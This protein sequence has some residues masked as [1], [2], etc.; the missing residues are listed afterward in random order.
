MKTFLTIF[1]SLAIL[2]IGTAQ[3]TRRVNNNVGISGT[4]VY[5]TA[6]AAHDAA[7]ANDIIIVDPSSTTYG[8]LTLTK[9]LK[10]YG[11]G[12][13][14]DTNSD[15]KAD[16]RASTFTNIYFNTGSGGSEMYGVVVTT[17]YIHGVSNITLSRNY[18]MS[19]IGIYNHNK[20]GTI[21]TNVAN[22][23]ITRN[24]ISQYVASAFTAPNTISSVLVNNNILG[25]LYSLADPAVQNWVI[26]NNTFTI[27]AANTTKIVNSVFE[28]NFFQAGG[29]GLVLTN[30][31]S[32]YNVSTAVTFSGGTGNVNSYDF[33]TNSELVGT[34]AGISPDEAL[35]IKAGSGLKTL[36]SS[37]SEVGAFGGTTPYII[38]G[39]PPIP[40]ITGA[41][42]TGTGDA[43]TPI[44]VTISV[45]SNN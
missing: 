4:N 19:T 44:K 1:L 45:K 22:I 7:V 8:D 25:Y 11:N 28:N 23:I 18:V 3:T 10:I 26:R 38:S 24:N 15:L 39:I 6:Q 29:V 31:T 9:P 16:Q 17:V 2:S 34:G 21:F 5:A 13:F 35:Q 41:I 37:S 42:N 43:T 20:V 36:G 12:Y 33:V 27:S 40:S 32:S 14:L 30:V